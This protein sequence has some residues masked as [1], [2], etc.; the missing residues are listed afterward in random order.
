MGN[1]Q[2]TVYYLISLSHSLALIVELY[3]KSSIRKMIVAESIDFCLQVDIK[4]K[5][6]LLSSKGSQRGW[7]QWLLELFGKEV[8]RLG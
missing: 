8:Y 5:Y 1:N 6:H 2:S 7:R 4:S 3:Y